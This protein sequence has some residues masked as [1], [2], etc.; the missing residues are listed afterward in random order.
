MQMRLSPLQVLARAPADTAGLRWVGGLLLTLALSGCVSPM[1]PQTA[2]SAPEGAAPADYEI[3]R[4]KEA[5]R[6]DGKLRS[7]R[8][9][10]RY[11]DLRVRMSDEHELGVTSVIQ[12]IGR[13]GREP[14]FDVRKGPE[15]IEFEVRYA[16]DDPESP[17]DFT[18]GRVDLVVFV[19][20]GASIDAE[21]GAGTLEV[22]RAQG[23]VKALTT[24]GKLS[25][26]SAATLDLRSS[27]GNIYARQMSSALGGDTSLSSASG[28]IE[29]GVPT[30]GDY[31]IDLEGSRGIVITEDWKEGEIHR[32][33]HGDT[34]F[35]FTRGG[36]AKRIVA[37]TRGSIQLSPVILLDQDAAAP[38]SR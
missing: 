9:V 10:N 25:V 1:E 26:S 12:R 33:E 13:P 29:L 8:L 19:Q 17:V 37:R 36:G 21:T 27:S 35:Q 14:V 23:P 2:R 11:G 31:V 18:R 3:I 30:H 20:R 7:V 28:N 15:Q 38:A 4:R 6:V 34:R 16:G 24:S 32:P 5:Y 22:R